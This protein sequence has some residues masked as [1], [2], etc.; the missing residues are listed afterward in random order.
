MTNTVHKSFDAPWENEP[1]KPVFKFQAKPCV[2]W[3]IHSPSYRFENNGFEKTRFFW[4]VR[5]L[6]AEYRTPKREPSM[7]FFVILLV[8]INLFHKKGEMLWWFARIT[9]LSIHDLRTRFIDWQMW[10][11]MIGNGSNSFND[12]LCF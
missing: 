1:S 10:Q 12:D 5:W 11:Q 2:T 8:V 7:Y 9:F 3:L 6:F 4:G